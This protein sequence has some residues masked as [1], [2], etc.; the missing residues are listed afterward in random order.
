M[1]I[2]PLSNRQRPIVLSFSGHDPSGG[3]GIQADIETIHALQCQPVTVISCLTIQNSVNVENI[4]P[5]AADFLHQQLTCLA[6]DFP[7]AAIKI[8]LLGSIDAV[9]TIRLFIEQN[10]SIPVVLDP[11][12]AAGGGTGLT[13]ESLQEEIYNRLIP[14]CTLVT[15]NAPEAR[16]LTKRANLLGCAENLINQGATSVLITGT[17]EETEEVTNTL[18]QLDEPPIAQR[19][20]RLP[21]SYHGSGCTL[22]SACAAGLAQ[23]K[24]LAD[25]CSQAQEFTWS[26]LHKGW[27][28]GKG[29]HI[30]LRQPES[31]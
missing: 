5:I 10:P 6:A 14:L 29:Q 26:S 30:P 18:Y 2:D 21:Y 27:K 1:K 20:Q 17:H 25:A 24:K 7:I 23:G 9:N 3:A 4:T 16:R 8:G 11:I 12:L 22:A 15:P 13:S 28:P 19:W 31:P